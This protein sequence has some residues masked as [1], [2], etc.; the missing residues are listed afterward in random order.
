MTEASEALNAIVNSRWSND[1][2]QAKAALTRF[3]DEVAWQESRSKNIPQIGGGPGRGYFQYEMA[4]GGGS[5]ANKTAVNRADY[6]Y[7]SQGLEVPQWIQDLKGKDVDFTQLSASQ[8]TAL[9]LY[10]SA[11]NPK[12]NVTVQGDSAFAKM[13]KTLV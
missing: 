12:T 1:Q 3:A 7:K 8:Q 13:I 4:S 5:G 11:Q 9:F 2:D 10:D 6:W